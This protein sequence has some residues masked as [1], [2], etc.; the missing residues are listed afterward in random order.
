MIWTRVQDLLRSRVEDC[1][2]P[3]SEEAKEEA[4]FLEAPFDWC[5]A[6]ELALLHPDGLALEERAGQQLLEAARVEVKGCLEL[7]RLLAQEGLPT[8]VAASGKL[9]GVGTL[10]GAIVLLDSKLQDIPNKPQAA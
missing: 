2:R 9:V 8:C 4:H 3:L 7:K 6:H 10:R 1:V 5:L